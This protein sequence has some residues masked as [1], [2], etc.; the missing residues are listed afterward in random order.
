MTDHRHQ[1]LIRMLQAVNLPG[2][3]CFFDIPGQAKEEARVS[4]CLF[5]LE[6]ADTRP[7][8]SPLFSTPHGTEAIKLAI[9]R[10]P[11]TSTKPSAEHDC[12]LD[13]LPKLSARNKRH[14]R[15]Q[16]WVRKQREGVGR[17][18][19]WTCAR[20][21]TRPAHPSAKNTCTP[22]SSDLAS[23][24]HMY[25]YMTPKKTW[26][27][28]YSTTA[29]TQQQHQGTPC[30]PASVGP[31]APTRVYLARCWGWADP[32]HWGRGI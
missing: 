26:L 9:V 21:P 13:R 2:Q 18:S 25:T 5:S 20:S 28:Y 4:A 7:R 24:H 23:S 19:G 6:A 30:P 10:Q 11:N 31:A 22:S 32:V 17:P 8:T 29:S 14:G 15:Y 3:S 12:P 1:V 27:S 16:E